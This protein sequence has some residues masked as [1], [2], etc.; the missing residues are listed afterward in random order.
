M[1]TVQ[2]QFHAATYNP[3]AEKFAREKALADKKQVEA[4][5]KA[6]EVQKE[7]AE[8]DAKK[9]EK[10]Q[11]REQAKQNEIEQ[12][13]FSFTRLFGTV[14]GTFFGIFIIFCLFFLAVLGSSMA[15]N[16]NI[17][18]S[19]PFRIFYAIYGFLFFFL[20]IPYVLGY[21]WFWKGKRPKFYS[22]I[23]IIPYHLDNQWAA[24][25]FSWLSYRPDDQIECLKE[26]I[27]ERDEHAK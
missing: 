3:E 22:L 12:K 6:V 20:V 5:A 21:R 7:K 25:L 24:L 26:W 15:T 14:A 23:P 16:L 9:L 2:Y 8:Q 1:N 11:K 18:H 27:K 13:T 10:K 17:Y 19:A 4:N